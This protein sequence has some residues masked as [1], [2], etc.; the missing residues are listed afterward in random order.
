MNEPETVELV[1]A[2]AAPQAPS[3]LQTPLPVMILVFL[4]FYVILIRPQQKRA[5][6]HKEMVAGLK[7]NDRVVTSGGLYG[8]VIEVNTDAVTLEI[9]PNVHVRHERSQ[10]GA[11]QKDKEK[12]DG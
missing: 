1:L 2:Q 7:K 3:F 5:K 4:V 8:R 10:V 12:K 11:M 9:A 6:E